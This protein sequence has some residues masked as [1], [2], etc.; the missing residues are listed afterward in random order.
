MTVIDQKVTLRT[1]K[2][3]LQPNMHSPAEIRAIRNKVQVSQPLFAEIIGV[4]VGTLR[5]WEQGKKS[6]SKMAR[7]LLDEVRNNPTYWQRWVLEAL[8]SK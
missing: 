2:L 6:P 3:R 8:S 1:V 7:R 4:S 5:T